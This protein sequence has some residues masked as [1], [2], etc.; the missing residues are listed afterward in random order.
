MYTNDNATERLAKD[1]TPTQLSRKRQQEEEDENAA[2]FQPKRAR[3]GKAGSTSS[4][5]SSSSTTTNT[6]TF[7]SEDDDDALMR[8][9]SSSTTTAITFDNDDDDDALMRMPIP[10]PSLKKTTSSSTFSASSSFTTNAA[11]ERNESM[12]SK[13]NEL[14][15][16]Q[17]AIC[18]KVNAPMG[19]PYS[20]TFE[21]DRAVRVMAAAGSG[22]TTTIKHI[23]HH[24]VINQGHCNIVYN[25]FN[26]VNAAEAVTDI[27][28]PNKIYYNAKVKCKT[29][30]SLALTILQDNDS[31]VQVNQSTPASNGEIQDLI[32]NV[33][34]D[35]I[36]NFLGP[37]MGMRLFVQKRCIDKCV[38]GI[39]KH[40]ESFMHGD[41]RDRPCFGNGIPNADAPCAECRK[42]LSSSQSSSHSSSQSEQEMPKCLN[43]AFSCQ[44]H[45]TW[46][47]EV[48]GP[49]FAGIPPYFYYPFHLWVKR[50]LE[51]VKILPTPPEMTRDLKIARKW[52]ARMAKKVWM[53]YLSYGNKIISYASIMKRV[54][55]HQFPLN[56]SVTLLL[57]D[58]AQDLNPCKF[59]WYLRQ[60]L[61]RQV[62]FVGDAL[63]MIYG[64][65]GAKS[66]SLMGMKEKLNQMIEKMFEGKKQMVTDPKTGSE[67]NIH[68]ANFFCDLTLT[69]SFRFGQTLADAANLISVAKHHSKQAS[70][71]K[72][73][74]VRGNVGRDHGQRG[75]VTYQDLLRQQTAEGK[76]Q[77]VEG[78]LTCLARRNGTI[79][80]A[81]L[82]LLQMDPTVKIA[83]NGKGPH[84]GRNKFK[85]IGKLLKHFYMIYVGRSTRF[86]ANIPHE[87]DEWKGKINL[88][89][90]T[91]VDDVKEEYAK[92]SIYVH[93]ITRLGPKE[94]AEKE[95]DYQ[96][97]S[98]K[99][100]VDYFI[101]HVIDEP[102]K[103]EDADVIFSTVHVSKGLEWNN[104]QL[105][106]DFGN[107]YGFSFGMIDRNKINQEQCF[108]PA[109]SYVA[110]WEKPG[111]AWKTGNDEDEANLLY[112]AAT[113]ARCLL[114]V[115]SRHHA[116]GSG[117]GLCMGSLIRNF[118]AVHKVAKLSIDVEEVSHELAAQNDIT[119][120]SARSFL[121]QAIYQDDSHIGV[122]KTL[123][124]LP[125]EF[126]EFENTLVLP[127]VEEVLSSS[128]ST[129]TYE[130][131]EE[132]E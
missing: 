101:K 52:L 28:N 118:A 104:V 44:Y 12:S 82:E 50:D 74:Y 124:E 45:D 119:L 126:N 76:F 26:K 93:I 113:R 69:K 13:F 6:L 34:K 62:F 100:K 42:R 15:C 131:P 73:Y 9:A 36:A 65:S 117:S 48:R 122:Y 35:E 71:F 72:R 3:R 109:S 68:K 10:P 38:R 37:M 47:N 128:S 116:S 17:K 4:T 66:R 112:V 75:R 40:V 92:Y 1:N 29:T 110:K 22:K 80:E 24:A 115:P 81:S 96:T 63:Q 111:F 64:F 120:A 8:T 49:Q 58:E 95:E 79:F 41:Q 127:T 99:K 78:G 25:V 125:K 5:T 20:T 83:L 7:N 70:T 57:V 102:I 94:A 18:F 114:S 55:L 98:L 106:G 32:K 105:L 39:F 107:G 60:S 59:D 43:D 97:S 27:E 129:I 23:V 77:R 123:F 89:W 87:F 21:K 61:H 53:E 132:K 14:T 51:T 16:E 85:K 54:Q 46:T 86:P 31:D 130:A 67:I 11:K 90:D 121:S 56:K 84:S 30:D 108:Q 19:S 91:V 88:D 33:C 103:P 2:A